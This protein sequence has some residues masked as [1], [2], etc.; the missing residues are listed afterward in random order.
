MAIQFDLLKQAYNEYE[1]EQRKIREEEE[2]RK[3]EE[4]QAKIKEFEEWLSD[5]GIV[6]DSSRYFGSGAV[7]SEADGLEF[8]LEHF[9]GNCALVIS[10]KSGAMRVPIYSNARASTWQPD[11]RR[12][13][14]HGV[15]EAVMAFISQRDS[16]VDKGA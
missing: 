14:L 6:A 1:E 3:E 10:S 2:R 8:S 15:Y 16:Q 4:R 5:L 12:R 11:D 13:A 9:R 7:I